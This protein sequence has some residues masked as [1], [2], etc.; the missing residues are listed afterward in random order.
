MIKESVFVGCIGANLSQSGLRWVFMHSRL[1]TALLVL[2]ELMFKSTDVQYLEI[3][4]QVVYSLHVH[5]E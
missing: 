4:S 5:L 1:C 2:L 3:S